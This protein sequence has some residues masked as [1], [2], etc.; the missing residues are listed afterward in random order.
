MNS[1][2]LFK[3]RLTKT[4]QFLRIFEFTVE[5]KTMAI[6]NSRS[7]NLFKKNYNIVVDDTKALIVKVWKFDKG[8]LSML[9]LSLKTQ[10]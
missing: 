5:S 6:G 1:A 10:E 4:F 2:G 8:G 3:N 7:K 9:M